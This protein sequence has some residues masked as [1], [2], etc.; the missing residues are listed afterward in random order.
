MYIMSI[1]HRCKKKF[2]DILTYNLHPLKML[3]LIKENKSVLNHLDFW[4][5]KDTY[6]IIENDFFL[7]YQWWVLSL[8]LSLIPSWLFF[9]LSHFSVI[10]VH[11][12]REK[13]FSHCLYIYVCTYCRL[14][15]LWLFLLP[16]KE[17]ICV[18]V[19]REERERKRKHIQYCY[20][21]TRNEPREAKLF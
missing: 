17:R 10:Y 20:Y 7:L 3:L 4:Q 11:L 18:P 2:L 6:T 16:M 9:S 5:K 21:G 19:Y 8:S 15:L 1:K 14:S 12:H 13:S